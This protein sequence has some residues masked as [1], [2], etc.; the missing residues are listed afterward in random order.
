MVGLGV[1]GFFVLMAFAAPFIFPV[2][3]ADPAAIIFAQGESMAPANSGLSAPAPPK[4]GNRS[5]PCSCEGVQGLPCGRTRPPPSSPWSWACSSAVGSG[6]YRNWFGA[7]AG[8][9]HRLVP[10]DPVLAAGDRVGV[11][12]P[13]RSPGWETPS[14]RSC[15][16]SGSRRGREP[17]GKL[18][19]D[20]SNNHRG[21][22]AL[23]GARCASS[24]GG[25]TGAR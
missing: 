22:P 10:G 25:R 2:N 19:F 3:P 4:P 7:L 13:R 20:P 6:H 21:G 17:R 5:W 12:G 23:P 1:L 8:A 24:R 18:E 9:G 11:R 14:T 16:S 15:W